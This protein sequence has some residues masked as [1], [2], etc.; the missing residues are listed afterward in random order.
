MR[1]N[2][3]PSAFIFD[4]FG[5]VISFDDKLVYRRIAEHCESFD[6]AMSSLEDLVSHPDLIMSKIALLDI[7]AYVVDTCGFSLSFDDFQSVWLE[8]YTESVV[9]MESILR[10]LSSRY[11]LVLLSNVDTCYWA[12]VSTLHPELKY[13]HTRLV[14]CELGFAKPDPRAFRHAASAAGK[15]PSECLFVDDKLENIEAARALGFQAHL[16]RDVAGLQKVLDSVGTDYG[17]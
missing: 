4:L 14:S 9:G 12:G 16:F 8:P 10:G 2:G 5:V 11:Q 1:E 13:F 15:T 17:C 6:V 3:S 7:Y